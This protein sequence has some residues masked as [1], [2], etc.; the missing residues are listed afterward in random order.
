MLL[1]SRAV[2]DGELARLLDLRGGRHL[3][4]VL[5]LVSVVRAASAVGEILAFWLCRGV[6][7]VSR[8]LALHSRAV[9]IILI[10]PR[11]VLAVRCSCGRCGSVQASAEV[12][13]K[14]N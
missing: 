9:A 2:E 13:P 5:A 7:A 3:G 12:S 1:D 6:W 8:V 10:S 14:A 4:L 11:A